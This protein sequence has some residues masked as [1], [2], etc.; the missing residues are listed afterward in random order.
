[1]RLDEILSL[2]WNKV[3]LIERLIDLGA[4]DTKEG[5]VKKAGIEQELYDVLIE[6]QTERGTYKPH[7]N[8]F[9]SVKGRKVNQNFFERKFRK[10]ADKAGFTDLKFHDFRHCYTVRKRREGHD[11]SVIKA[12]TGHHTD[13]M[14]NWYDKVDQ[15][16]IQEMAGFT[17]IS[18]EA[19]Q[20]QIDQLV[21]SA[22]D[23][24]IPLG[25]V[26]ALIGRLWRTAA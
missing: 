10:L 25:A 12:Q 24:G 9:L 19:I 16:E 23:H 21:K 8:V 7:D 11:R 1:M 26:Q 3:N 5:D 4:D 6:I 15:F 20:M 22:K 17:Q 2:T 13:S 14:F 18:C